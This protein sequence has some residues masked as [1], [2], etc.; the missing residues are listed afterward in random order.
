MGLQTGF[1]AEVRRTSMEEFLKVLSV[2]S[3]EL[4]LIVPINGR[5]QIF[6]N[7]IVTNIC[8]QEEDE[9]NY[10]D[11]QTNGK[12]LTFSYFIDYGLSGEYE[13]FYN[14]FIETLNLMGESKYSIF[15]E[16]DDKY[17]KSE[18]FDNV[19]YI[20]RH[21]DVYNNYFNTCTDKLF[22]EAISK[23][24]CF[25]EMKYIK[26]NIYPLLDNEN[27]KRYETVIHKFNMFL[28]IQ[29]CFN[30]LGYTSLSELKLEFGKQETQQYRAYIEDYKANNPESPFSAFF[31]LNPIY[32][33]EKGLG[34][35]LKNI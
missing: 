30:N 32:N 1:H 28:F 34:F 22:L 3:G 16:F 19:G 33:Y 20:K 4:Y 35:L 13:G 2:I 27:D 29:W 7:G 24:I 17:N 5:T 26:K 23:K 8:Y 15:S 9:P 10:N 11:G 31:G 6:R 14:D 12:K 21:L 18:N 25:E